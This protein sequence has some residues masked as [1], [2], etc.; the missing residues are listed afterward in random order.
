MKVQDNNSDK[1]N[2]QSCQT[3]VTSSYLFDWRT[4]NDKVI[5]PEYFM[6][7]DTYDKEMN[8]YC[9][10]RRVDGATEVLLSKVIK[11]EN[12]FEKEVENLAKY[13]NAKVL[14]SY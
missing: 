5:E 7:V 13:F 11:D 10:T 3:V 14:R 2:T 1:D 4:I 12:D 6:G 9:L 8:A